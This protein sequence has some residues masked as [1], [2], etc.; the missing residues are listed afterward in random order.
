MKEEWSILKT[1]TED[2]KYL[3]FFTYFEVYVKK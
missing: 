2:E 3:L 1:D